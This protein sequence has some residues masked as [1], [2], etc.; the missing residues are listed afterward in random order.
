MKSDS[1]FKDKMGRFLTQSLF[2]ETV[3][4]LDAA[5]YTLQD[6]DREF[7]G[8]TYPSIHRLYIE[9]GDPTEYQF[10]ME[11]FHS[12]QQW[13]KICNS[14]AMRP[15]VD[16]WRDELEVKL[17]SQG[18]RKMIHNSAGSTKDAATAAKWLADR[19]WNKR[20]AG[21]PSKAEVERQTKIAAGIEAEIEKDAERMLRIVN[22]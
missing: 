12:W 3:Y 11:Y 6:R 9:M 7:K 16:K 22:D 4:D 14:N 20:K 18:V 5:L 1:K 8:K 21:T 15:H 17:R 2:L 13:L 10:A 19:G